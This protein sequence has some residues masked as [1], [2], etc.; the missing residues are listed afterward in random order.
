MATPFEPRIHGPESNQYYED[1]SVVG[2]VESRLLDDGQRVLRIDEW[3]S[4]EPGLGHADR[5][6]RWLRESH[7]HITVNGAG[8]VDDDGPDITVLYWERQFDKGLVD[9]ILLDDGT[10]YRNRPRAPAQRSRTPRP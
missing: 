9:T 5:A 10:A 8:E 1:G 2:A 3:S 7:Q 4:A 6:L